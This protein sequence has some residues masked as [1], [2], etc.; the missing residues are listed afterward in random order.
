[1]A[2]AGYLRDLHSH[3]SNPPDPRWPGNAP[4]ARSFR[5]KA[6]SLRGSGKSGVATRNEARSVSRGTDRKFPGGST[7]TDGADRVPYRART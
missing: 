2:E 1:M 6:R 3:G 7:A 4:P 5:W